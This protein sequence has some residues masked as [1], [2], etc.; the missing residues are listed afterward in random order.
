MGCLC[1]ATVARY[2]CATG[3]A[4]LLHLNGHKLGGSFSAWKHMSL[5][6]T[7]V[8]F[9]S[10]RYLKT[11]IMYSIYLGLQNFSVFLFHFKI[12]LVFFK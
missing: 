11:S 8:D 2:V 12:V 3:G 7:H 1:V 4:K 10:L 6:S 5:V 9:S